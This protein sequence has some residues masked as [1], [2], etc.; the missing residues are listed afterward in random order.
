MSR[1]LAPVRTQAAT[2]AAHISRA[3]LTISMV[4]ILMMSIGAFGVSYHFLHQQTQ[5]HLHTLMALTAS[6][7]VAPLQFHD[8][9][10]ATEVLRAIPRQ[11]GIE[12]A[13]MRDDAGHLLAKVERPD[14]S[15]IASLARR[16]DATRL[17]QQIVVDDRH[18]GSVTL[19]GGNE[20]LLS[21]LLGLL[22]WCVMAMLVIALT[23]LILARRR[24]RRITQPIQELRVVVQRLIEHR[25]F[26]Q[27]APPS[28]L[29][30][31]EDLRREFNI[32]L[33]EIA[34]RDHQLRKTNAALQR[35]AYVDALTGLP[36]RA[37][38][39]QALLKIADEAAA[40]RSRAC[41][42][43]LDIDGFKS[44]NDTLGHATGDD[45]LEA[46]G[47]RLR[48]WQPQ[49]GF[50]ARI[51]G[52][53]L[54]LLLAPFEEADDA[55]H[56]VADLQATLELPISVNGRSLH[57]GIS[58]GYAIYPD[59]AQDVDRLI[60]LADQ[61]MYAA[62]KQRYRRD[63]V[64]RWSAPRADAARSRQSENR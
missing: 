31:V 45:L 32:L 39:E 59:M 1:P 13:E 35:V 18:L 33:D 21:A 23:S 40:T 8:G 64:T 47:A 62:K 9:A 52:D 48:T 57:P 11:E 6:E 3:L 19:S 24:T 55:R 26:T 29:S 50:A 63:G 15:F 34:V 36:N 12:L 20:P 53:E 30:E 49:R 44:V 4:S 46:I 2:S 58:I 22:G 7:S 28:D 56:L 41:L 43:Y 27:R 17:T 51:G 16:F 42:F 60:E 10:T 61:S 37:M 38:F 25:D 5:R 14:E 54:V